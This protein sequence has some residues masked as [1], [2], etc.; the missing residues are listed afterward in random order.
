MKAS[1]DFHNRT[2]MTEMMTELVAWPW[3]DYILHF[4]KT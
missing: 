4:Y 3:P 1:N 2:V